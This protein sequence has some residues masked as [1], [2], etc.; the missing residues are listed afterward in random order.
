MSLEEFRNFVFGLMAEHR[1]GPSAD[2]N[3]LDDPVDA[4][5]AHEAMEMLERLVYRMMLDGKPNVRA[6]LALKAF[7]QEMRPWTPPNQDGPA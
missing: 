3:K 4:A 7:K 5:K 2:P 1:K 6:A